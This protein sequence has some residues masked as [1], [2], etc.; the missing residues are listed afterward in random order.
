MYLKGLDLL[1]SFGGLQV[2]LL[3]RTL[4]ATLRTLSFRCVGSSRLLM[5][6]E[7]LAGPLVRSLPSGEKLGQLPD[8][9][10]LIEYERT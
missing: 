1:A 5:I 9:E 10:T 7:R 6:S 3:V 8:S 2:Y 4:S